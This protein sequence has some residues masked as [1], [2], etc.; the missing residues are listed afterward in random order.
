MT[1]EEVLDLVQSLGYRLKDVRWLQSAPETPDVLELRP[2]NP[3][4]WETEWKSLRDLVGVTG[5]WPL[6]TTRAVRATRPTNMFAG[7]GRGSASVARQ[8]ATGRDEDRLFET[9]EATFLDWEEEPPHDW[10]ARQ[11]RDLPAEDLDTWLA[12]AHN[13]LGA[14]PTMRDTAEWLGKR[15]RGAGHAPTMTGWHDHSVT[16]FNLIPS[17]D[18]IEG[19]AYLHL[20]G[21]DPVKELTV[22]RRWARELN[23][24]LVGAIGTSFLFSLPE[25]LDD[26][27]QAWRL[28][29][30]T[31]SL[32]GYSLSIQFNPGGPWASTACL[33]TTQK[34]EGM[35]TH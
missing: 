5:R 8:L 31:I 6:A 25:P 19:L 18:S 10:L 17:P 26:I 29:V 16:A 9:V 13:V 32:W 4:D 7:P 14:S 28:A 21:S 30:E 34:F 15:R 12:D 1:D 3:D 35:G 23:V 27:D 33:M 2:K 24:E 22:C 20:I 11:L